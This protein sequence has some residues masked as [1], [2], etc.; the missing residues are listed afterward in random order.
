MSKLC[1][2]QVVG[3]SECLGWDSEQQSG[4]VATAGTTAAIDDPTAVDTWIPDDPTAGATTDVNVK[5]HVSARALA[6]EEYL[7]LMVALPKLE[8]SLAQQS[9]SYNP[10]IASA[11]ASW[12]MLHEPKVDFLAAGNATDF[13]SDKIETIWTRRPS[14]W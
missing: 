6:S 1:R 2:M 4:G 13:D 9:E 12:S 11:S 3:T 7:F 5:F 8:I 14:S 10:A